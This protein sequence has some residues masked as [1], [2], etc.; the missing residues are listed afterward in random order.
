MGADAAMRFLVETHSIP[1]AY[2]A[3]LRLQLGLWC[4]SR[5]V[6]GRREVVAISLYSLCNAV[7]HLG[8][9]FLHQHLQK[10]PGLFTELCDLLQS[11]QAVGH[12]AGAAALRAT[13]AILD[14]RYG[15][16]RA[17]MTQLSQMLGLSVPHGIV[18]CA[19]RELL[20]EAP[21]AEKLADHY[22]VL[23]AA[24]DLFQITTASNHQSTVQ[25]GHAGILA[26]LELM[27]KT[28]VQSLPAVAAM[29]RC[30][31]LA[32]EVSGSTA[33]VL[34]REFRGLPAFSTRLQQEVDLLMA[35]AFQ[36]DI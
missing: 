29:L 30:L 14:S 1:E 23:M 33:L 7:K 3:A 9:S 28:D 4:H 11:L 17:E 8:P 34:F 25:L 32:A 13:G 6:Q 35:L 19:L 12:E 5:S 24:L 2:H 26:M 10:R 18:A 21:P 20:G 27:Q 22:K 15:Q 31:E 16:G 36:G